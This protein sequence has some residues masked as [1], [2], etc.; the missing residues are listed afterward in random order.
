MYTV[1]IYIYICTLCIYIY[2]YTVFICIY[3]YILYIYIC[4][5]YIYIYTLCLYV[6]IY[7]IYIYIYTV[8][9]YSIYIYIYIYTVYIYIYIYLH[10]IL[11]IYCI[12][13]LYILVYIMIDFYSTWYMTGWIWDSTCSKRWIQRFARGGG[14]GTEPWMDKG[15]QA[16]LETAR[17][18][19]PPKMMVEWDFMGFVWA[20]VR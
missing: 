15:Q 16:R 14:A 2:I 7:C 8:Y 20:L 3:I 6:Y 13:I 10:C 11:N 19:I 12:Y 1:Y 9:I 17:R 5:L 18:G 4:T